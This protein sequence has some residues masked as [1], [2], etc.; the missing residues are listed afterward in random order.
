MLAQVHDFAS[1]TGILMLLER[2]FVEIV[3]QRSPVV[4][5]DD[6]DDALI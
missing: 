1:G 3:N 2:T 6:V 4:L 5:L